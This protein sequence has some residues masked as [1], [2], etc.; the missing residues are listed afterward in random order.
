[1]LKNHPRV[2]GANCPSCRTNLAVKIGKN[3]KIWDFHYYLLGKSQIF[4]F[5]FSILTAK[6]V[7]LDG[8]L[9][10]KTLGWFISIMNGD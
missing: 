2:F 10:P 8:Q 3:S 5:F 9:A 1:M 4:E 7:R 6:L